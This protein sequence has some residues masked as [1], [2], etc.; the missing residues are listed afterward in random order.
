AAEHQAVQAADPIDRRSLRTDGGR[1]AVRAVHLRDG[2]ADSEASRGGGTCPRT[3]LAESAAGTGVGLSQELTIL[4]SDSRSRNVGTAGPG[5]GHYRFWG[6]AWPV[7]DWPHA[8]SENPRLRRLDPH[9]P[10]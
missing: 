9:P 2:D 10:A 6:A 7:Y 3:D 5:P 8:C 4:V 1:R